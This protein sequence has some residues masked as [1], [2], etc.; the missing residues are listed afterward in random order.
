MVL[1]R[2]E[3]MNLLEW[4]PWYSVLAS[5]KFPKASGVY[6]LGTSFNSFFSPNCVYNGACS[7]LSDRPRDH[8]KL[9]PQK[10]VL[11]SDQWVPRA[12]S[13]KVI[14]ELTAVIP[15]RYWFIRWAVTDNYIEEEIKLIQYMSGLVNVSHQG[16]RHEKGQYLML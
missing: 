16:K 9:M 15:K 12:G 2:S 6:Q 10:E 1:K 11:I 8:F 5:P 4:S 7:N 14:E 13:S 3:T